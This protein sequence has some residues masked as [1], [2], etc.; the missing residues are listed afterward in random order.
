MQPGSD[1]KAL[2]CLSGTTTFGYFRIS[3]CHMQR[4]GYKLHAEWNALGAICV[5]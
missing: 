2:G 1:Y 3:I 5:S 4:P